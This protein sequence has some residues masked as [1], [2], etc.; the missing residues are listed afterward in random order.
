MCPLPRAV[1]TSKGNLTYQQQAY[2]LPVA[3]L[4][5][6]LYLYIHL[7][8]IYPFKYSFHF[9]LTLS[10]HTSW[11]WSVCRQGEQ[12]HG[13]DALREAGEK[14]QNLNSPAAFPGNLDSISN[15]LVSLT[16]FPGEADTLFWP[17]GAP[18]IG[19]VH[20]PLYTGKNTHTHRINF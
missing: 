3:S 13:Q 19:A 4:L 5:S 1:S 2:L 10:F 15:I 16:L 18:S 6:C 17:L 7:N 12:C 14:A 11:N 9:S 20:R 8:F